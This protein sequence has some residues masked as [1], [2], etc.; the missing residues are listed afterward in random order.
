MRSLVNMG[1]INDYVHARFKDGFRV[2]ARLFQVMGILCVLATSVPLATGGY[3]RFFWTAVEGEVAGYTREETGKN[4]NG[5]AIIIRHIRYTFEGGDGNRQFATEEINVRQANALPKRH[6]IAV[7]VDPADGRRST[8]SVGLYSYWLAAGIM[9]LVGF[10]MFV[11]GTIVW[12]L[13]WREG[14]TWQLK[15]RGN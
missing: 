6:K 5:N 14:S 9:A 3:Q 2:R 15:E 13:A 11:A 7:Y 10:V 12:L 4:W 8:T 1:I